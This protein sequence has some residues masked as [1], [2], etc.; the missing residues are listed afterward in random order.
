[1]EPNADY[2]PTGNSIPVTQ[3]ELIDYIISQLQAYDTDSTT[4]KSPYTYVLI[5]KTPGDGDDSKF[6]E[7][8][9]EL[10]AV[11]IQ[12]WNARKKPLGKPILNKPVA[13]PTKSPNYVII[14]VIILVALLIYSQMKSK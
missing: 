1:M 5:Y 6:I 4:M 2:K 12:Q 14:I 9:E 10:Q 11:V 7:V 8:P 13:Q 3:Q